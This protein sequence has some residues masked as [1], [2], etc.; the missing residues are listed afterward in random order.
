MIEC[1]VGRNTSYNVST[2]S[3][4]LDSAIDLPFILEL[5]E[6]ELYQPNCEHGINHIQLI[7]HKPK[8]LF[9]PTDICIGQIRAIEIIGKVHQTTKTQDEEIYYGALN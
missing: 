5:G 6:R 7:P 1:Q 3:L 4:V 8:L 2:R 9:H